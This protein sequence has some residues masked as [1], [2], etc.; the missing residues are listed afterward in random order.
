MPKAH[1]PRSGSMQFWPRK[2]AKRSYPR[3]RNNPNSNPGL[4]GFAGYKAGM[5][6]VIITDNRKTSTTKG[7]DI[8]CPI[9][10]IE[11]PPI[12]IFSA[13]FYK[14]TPSGAALSSEIFSKNIDK[15]L[16]KKVKLPKASTKKLDDV[17][18][19]D[20]IKAV[21]YT[22]PSLTGIGKKKPELFEI[23]I[24]GTKEEQLAFIKE[25]FDK[26]VP[27]EKVFQE[28]EQVDVHSITKGKGTK[29]P[30]ERFGIGL[31]EHKSEKGVR[32]PGSLGPW[33]GQGHILYR[34]AH[35]GQHGYHQRTEYNKWLLKIGSNP[36]EINP[37]GGFINYGL[38]K[39]NYV[40]LKG[41][42]SGPKKR[43]I[44]L[45]K[46]SRPSKKIPKEAPAIQHISLESKQGN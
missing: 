15:N 30:V 29:G 9:T 6:H 7:S 45:T 36:E 33:R 22:Q 12:K 39:N 43:L 18:E 3:L 2:R 41:S 19:Y 23:R 31:K 46:S 13:R 4:V 21:V 38:V 42:V 1:K 17:K 14:N 24:G 35:A 40:L 32:N 27:I 10:V 16:A 44:I 11:C 8:I 34:V 28:G 20:F 26:E 37:K 25:Y 5:T